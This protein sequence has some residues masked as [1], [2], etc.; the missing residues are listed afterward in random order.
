MVKQIAVFLENRAGRLQELTE[1]LCAG[2]VDLL[3]MNI[4]D[5]TEFGI[6]RIISRDNDKAVEVLK[7]AG[8]TVT[9][10]ELIG[11][12]VD[13]KPGALSGALKLLKDN[14]IS[15]EYLYAFARTADKSALIF[16]KTADTAH[17]ESLLKKANVKLLENN[18]I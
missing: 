7:K 6:C 13:D 2:G 16:C 3:S 12:V 15:V 1:M 9:V 14:N 5:T 11:I 8:L 4:A 18:M 10:S 17:A